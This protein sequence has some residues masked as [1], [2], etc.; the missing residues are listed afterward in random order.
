MNKKED[1]KDILY[2]S[3]SGNTKNRG[4]LGLSHIYNNANN[5][6]RNTKKEM[7]YRNE[8][9]GS[10]S[11][12]L[13]NTNLYPYQESRTLHNNNDKDV[14]VFHR[15]PAPSYSNV[16]QE[17]FVEGNYQTQE[18]L[19][20]P[21]RTPQ[22]RKKQTF[23]FK[24]EEY[25]KEF[26][27]KNDLKD[28]SD[29]VKQ[30]LFKIDNYN[31]LQRRN[32][33]EVDER[34]NKRKRKVARKNEMDISKV[35]CKEEDVFSDIQSILSNRNK[36]FLSM[37]NGEESPRNIS[38]ENTYLRNEPTTVSKDHITLIIQDVMKELEME[39]SHPTNDTN[40][41]DVCL[42]VSEIIPPKYREVF[43][44]TLF[45]PIQSH[46]STFLLNNRY[47]YRHH[48][49]RNGINLRNIT[50]SCC[51]LSTDKNKKLTLS[52]HVTSDI[53]LYSSTAS[54]K[55]A[56]LEM[57]IINHL[58]NSDDDSACEP[59]HSSR[60]TKRK[61]TVCSKG[62]GVER[63]IRHFKRDQYDSERWLSG[64]RGAS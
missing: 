64:G 54:G 24:Y 17:S 32:K 25:N 21:K 6:Q 30:P 49:E 15:T 45:N 58:I 51:E 34:D 47:Y 1:K 41:R 23:P 43:K 2:E 61:D 37:N 4:S 38:E 16:F 13:N 42:K 11:F 56:A 44:Y 27:F 19:L 35:V 57:A 28:D 40:P 33:W 46:F 62:K 50:N 36:D 26:M 60:N 52:P 29:E 3:I 48:I 14:V 22:K 39:Y 10:F 8:N 59:S 18:D 12:Q 7:F 31:P 5:I 20:L 53:V 63:C 9:E 55:T